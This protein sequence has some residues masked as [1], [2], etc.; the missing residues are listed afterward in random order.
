[1]K[2]KKAYGFIYSTQQVFYMHAMCG[3]VLLHWRTPSFSFLLGAR[4]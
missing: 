3:V 4:R 2:L 1:M